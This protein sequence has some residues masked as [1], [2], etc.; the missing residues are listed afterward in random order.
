MVSSFIMSVT[1]SLFLL[2]VIKSGTRGT[3]WI[4]YQGFQF[5]R[6]LEIL[7]E[8]QLPIYINGRLC[9]CTSVK[10][11]L[12]TLPWLHP[13]SELIKTYFINLWKYLPNFKKPSGGIKSFVDGI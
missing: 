1:I 8:I 7:I 6:Q 12:L 2:V 4:I 10:T 13:T 5:K 3:R 9:F 11:E